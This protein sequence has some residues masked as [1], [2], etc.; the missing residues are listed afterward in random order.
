MSTSSEPRV[1]IS[2]SHEDSRWC[3]MFEKHLGALVPEKLL[4]IWSDQMLRVGEYWYDS[5]VEAI[6]SADVAILLVSAD[7]L[8]SDFIR[9]EEVPRLLERRRQEGMLIVPVI[10]RPCVWR[11]IP[12]LSSMLV[13]PHDGRPLAV[14]PR[15]FQIEAEITSIIEEVLRLVG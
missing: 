2:Y 13:R 5:I 10:C 9:L 11:Q 14:R 1:I 6:E 4:R 15:V 12:W 8:A 7:Y 3:A